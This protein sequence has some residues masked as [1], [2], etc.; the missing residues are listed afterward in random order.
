MYIIAECGMAHL[1]SVDLAELMLETAVSAG[2]DA[3][4]IQAFDPFGTGVTYS[5]TRKITRA[6]S[7]EGISILKD[8]CTEVDIEF[9]ITPHDRWAMNLAIS[10]EVDYI[11]M[12]SGEMGNWKMYEQAGASGIPLI[13]STGMSTFDQIDEMYEHTGDTVKYLLHCVSK[14]PATYN[15]ANLP[16]I[17]QLRRKFFDCSKIGYSDHT[18]NAN[19]VNDAA[20]KY[21]A[22]CI[23]MH[24]KLIDHPTSGDAL[25][26]LTPAKFHAR[27]DLLRGVE[28]ALMKKNRRKK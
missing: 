1:G 28:V 13:C 24:M 6:L 23:E 15:Q 17:A 18:K 7:Q 16:R 22:D 25:V 2:A 19:V 20:N 10:L 9:I 3:F 8:L 12:G 11:K 27:C 26:G 21:L 5:G 14:Y 4:K